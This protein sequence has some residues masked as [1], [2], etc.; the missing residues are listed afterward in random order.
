MTARS[1]DRAGR[2]SVTPTQRVLDALSE[3]DLVEL[4]DEVCRRCAVTH[5]GVCGLARTR[6]ISHA[7]HELWWRLRHHPD[8]RF[9]L[10]EIG[11]L[12]QRH[13]ATIL[14]GIRAHEHR[15]GQVLVMT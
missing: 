6:A 3:R 7:R 4:L 11:R 12:F 15:L 2:K 10:D 13:H 14:H 1:N 9:S 5:A 8:I